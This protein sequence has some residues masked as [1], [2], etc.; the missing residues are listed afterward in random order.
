MDWSGSS[1]AIVIIEI[2][3]WLR[4]NG[5]SRYNK[6]TSFLR[7]VSN[8]WRDRFCNPWY[9]VFASMPE[10]FERSNSLPIS[11]YLVL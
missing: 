5:V 11:R 8:G 7:L 3:D 4:S 2:S 9:Y 6:Q 10:S 1:W